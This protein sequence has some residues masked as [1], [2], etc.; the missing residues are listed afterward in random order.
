MPSFLSKAKVE[1]IEMGRQCTVNCG[2]YMCV[3][4]SVYICMCESIGH[5]HDHG[6]GTSSS[7]AHIIKFAQ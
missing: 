5:G 7:W 4:V 1:Y 6:H 3:R 2:V